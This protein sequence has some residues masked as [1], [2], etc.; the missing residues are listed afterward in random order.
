MSDAT[1]PLTPESTGDAALDPVG[2]CLAMLRRMAEKGMAMIEAV[3]E[4]GSP[5][6]AETFAKLSRAVRLT[7]NLQLKLTAA[8]RA[9]EAAEA[10]KVRAQKA[11]LDG[12]AAEDP[13]APLKT[14]R[15]ARVRELFRDVIDR[16]IDDPEEN[17]I[18]SEALDERLL[19]DEAYDNIEDLPLRDIIERLCADLKLRP[20]WNRWTVD[21]WKAKPPF[22]RPRCSLFAQ[23]SRTPILGDVPE[24]DPLE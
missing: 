21:G 7:V 4:D 1:T 24:I 17:D 3:K 11:V 23:P 5:E 10:E 2:P 20:D 22:Y 9:D 8:R 6:S 15:K 16:E 14:G 18:L 13:F 12:E 19:F